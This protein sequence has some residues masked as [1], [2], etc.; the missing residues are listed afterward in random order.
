MIISLKAISRKIQDGRGIWRIPGN[1]KQEPHKESLHQLLS[2]KRK[3]HHEN[4]KKKKN[5][6]IV[7]MKIC[8]SLN[9]QF[10]KKNEAHRTLD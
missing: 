7:A 6:A 3:K 9:P 5:T 4:A 1:S 2:I 8:S 10:R